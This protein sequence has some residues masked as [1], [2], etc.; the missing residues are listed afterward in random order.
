MAA[1][2]ENGG[3]LNPEFEH[4]IDLI[5]EGSYYAAHD[6]LEDVWRGVHGWSKP[7]YQGMVQVAISLHHFSTGNLAGAQSVMAKCRKNL[8]EFPESF[9]GVDV[10]DLAAQ[11]EAWQRA[12]AAGGP[13]PPKVVVRIDGTE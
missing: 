10:R 1:T 13:Y 8:G 11:L 3:V 6:A 4:G 12:M 2:W 7:F 5:N 9:C